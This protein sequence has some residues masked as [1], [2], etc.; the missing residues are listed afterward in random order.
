MLGQEA[1][2]TLGGIKMPLAQNPLAHPAVIGMCQLNLKLVTCAYGLP[3][4]TIQYF[5]APPIVL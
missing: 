3:Y 5:V 1:V 4:V 2:L